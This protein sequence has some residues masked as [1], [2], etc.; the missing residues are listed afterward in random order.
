[1][2]VKQLHFLILR[3]R[4][5]ISACSTEESRVNGLH[6]GMVTDKCFYDDAL[7]GK[8]RA[9]INLRGRFSHFL[10]ALIGDT[11]I[12][13]IPQSVKKSLRNAGSAAFFP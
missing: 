8:R 11:R 6:I 2:G 9:G 10:P 7:N 5:V 1:M 13:A 12:W 4:C 3:L